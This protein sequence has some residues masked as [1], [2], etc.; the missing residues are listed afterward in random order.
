MRGRLWLDQ[1]DGAGAVFAVELPSQQSI[2][3]AIRE[4]A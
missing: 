2:A 3:Q 4:P 1:Q